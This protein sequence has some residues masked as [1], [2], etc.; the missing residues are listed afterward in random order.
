MNISVCI[1]IRQQ[2]IGVVLWYDVVSCDI[3][4]GF[5]VCRQVSFDNFCSCKPIPLTLI[6]GLK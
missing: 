4:V 2:K 6:I 1:F 5:G 3:D